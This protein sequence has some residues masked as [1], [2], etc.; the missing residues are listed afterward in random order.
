[1]EKEIVVQIWHGFAAVHFTIDYQL[2]NARFSDRE[3]GIPS[4]AEFLQ[5][6][7]GG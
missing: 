3:T 6:I 4:H 7:H 1:M 2:I 5:I